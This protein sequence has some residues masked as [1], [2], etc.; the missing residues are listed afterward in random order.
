M[1]TTM[2]KPASGPM[3]MGSQVST[4]RRWRSGARPTYVRCPTQ[5]RDEEDDEQRNDI[6][7]WHLNGDRAVRLTDASI[8]NPRVVAGGVAVLGTN[9][10][11]YAFDGMFGRPSADLIIVDPESGERAVAAEGVSFPYGVSSTGR[12]V[13]FYSGGQFHAYDR[14]SGQTIDLSV[15]AGVSFANAANDHPDRKSVV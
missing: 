1:T 14:D 15:A 6:F 5:K 4:R 2:H 8:D 3:R 9:D 7:A 13:H 11:P 10:D 12:Y